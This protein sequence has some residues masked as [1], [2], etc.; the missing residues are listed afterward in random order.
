MCASNL[1]QIGAAIEFHKTEHDG[2]Y[3][4]SFAELLQTQD[5]SIDL[6]I[7]PASNTSSPTTWP[8]AWPDACGDY[9]YLGSGLRSDVPGDI[10]VAYERVYEFHKGTTNVL[11]TD[12]RVVSLALDE[13]LIAFEKSDGLR[14]AWEQ[15]RPK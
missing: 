9:I 2:R 3:P 5:I 6:F 8:S 13:F 1:R 15:K 11:F 7:C 12:G 10:V 14:R 4:S